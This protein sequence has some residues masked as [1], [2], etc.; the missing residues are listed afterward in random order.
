MSLPQP[1]SSPL[2]L[3]GVLHFSTRHQQVI[4]IVLAFGIDWSPQIVLTANEFMTEK[5]PWSN[6]GDFYELERNCYVTLS[7]ALSQCIASDALEC[8]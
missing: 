8:Q 2:Q 6:F 4:F 7:H 1:T 5:K 3:S